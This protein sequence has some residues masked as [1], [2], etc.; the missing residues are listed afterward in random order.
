[1]A[2]TKSNITLKGLALQ[3]VYLKITKMEY[4][5][6]KKQVKYTIAAFP[7]KE[8]SIQPDCM[9]CEYFCGTHDIEMGQAV[10]DILAQIYE[11]I[12]YRLTPESEAELDV[13]YNAAMAE[14]NRIYQETIAAIECE[15]TSQEYLEAK[16]EAGRILANAESAAATRRHRFD[17]M[18]ALFDGV[19]D[20]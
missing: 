2:F 8:Y 9:I 14:P 16:D 15:E 3:S 12:K 6:S 4:Y 11:E 20:C 19:T 17:R 10:P 1:M 7:S 5:P 18:R 13:Q